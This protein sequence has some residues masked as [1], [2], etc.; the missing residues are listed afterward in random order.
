M[1]TIVHKRGDTF[2]LMCAVA[3]NEVAQDITGWAIASQVRKGSI[4][5]ETLTIE[6]ISAAAGTFMLTS[7]QRTDSWPTG[8]L[9]LDVEYTLSSGQVISTETLT[10]SC[11][12]DVTQP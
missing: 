9:Q 12:K 10:I 3:I 4:L 7:E 5:V 8:D 1:A 2:K 6:P 11:I